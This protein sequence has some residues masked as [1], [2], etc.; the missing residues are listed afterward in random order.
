METGTYLEA[1]VA[2]VAAVVEWFFE[3]VREVPKGDALYVVEHQALRAA[4]EIARMLVQTWLDRQDGGHCGH[5]WFD[6]AGNQWEFKQY[7]RRSVQTLV[8]QVRV[9]GAQ[10]YS[11]TA[12]PRTVVPHYGE[13]GLPRGRY[14]RAMEEV[15]ALAGAGEVYREGLMLVNR[16]TGADVSVHKAESTVA[17]WG[18]EAKE[19]A[20]A[21]VREPQSSAE[22]IAATRP[23]KGLRQCVTVDGTMVQTTEGWREV[24]LVATYRFD[25]EGNKQG[26]ALYAGTLHYHED[27][28]DL[29]WWLMEHS[30]ASRAEVLVWLGDGAPWVWKVQELLAP[31]AVAIVDFYHCQ[32]RLSALGRALYGDGEAGRRWSQKWTKN[33]YLGKVEALVRELA[34]LRA[35]WGEPPGDCADDD[36]RKL[37]A[38][39]HRYFVNNAERMRYD[40]YVAR[41]YPIGSGVVESSC[42]H[43]VGLRMKR[44]AT[45]AWTERNA[46]AMVQLRCLCAS[47]EWD[48][49]WGFEELWKHIRTLAA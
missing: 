11:A 39:A 7:V 24:K 42:R 22:R 4:R 32:A 3:G 6:E 28:A 46:E 31:E 23:I 14:S 33:L 45:M 41:G 40:V 47:G 21:Q 37:L 49:F 43:I 35:S 27:Y 16:L 8:G 12:E 5:R 26:Q 9:K 48:R 2:K 15:I 30:G 36:P 34:G 25:Q 1:I 19:K 10:Y 13:L 18:R 44:T 17:A 20:K 29:A 38:E